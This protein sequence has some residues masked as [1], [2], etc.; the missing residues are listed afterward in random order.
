MNKNSL[1]TSPPEI[2]RAKEK[3][4]VFFSNLNAD[5]WGLTVL[6]LAVIALAFSPIFTKLGEIELSPTSTIF[7]RLW[8]ATMMLSCRQLVKNPSE[9]NS[10][11]EAEFRCDRHQQS[12][13]ILASF[14]ATVSAVLWAISLI[15][16]SVASSTVIRSLTPLFISTGAW[17][18]LKQRCDRQFAVGMMLA[19]VG[20]MA[21]GW[22]D[23][24][25]GA[26]RLVGDEIA[27]LSA[28][29]HGINLLII[30]YLRDRGCS[31]ER[32]LR[33][34]CGCGALLVFPVVYLT[35][36]Q[37]LPSSLQGWLAVIALAFICQTLGQGLLIHSLRQFSSS[38]VG[39]FTLLKPLITSVLAWAIFAE[40]I[41]LA[42]GVALILILTGIYLAKTSS[43]A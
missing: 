12:L 13:L 14:S 39:I 23:F 37:L 3:T 11:L 30:G 22:D 4:R 31:T 43:S 19:I 24:Q 5:I 21:I 8:I 16:T 32:V 27:L 38:F 15:H 34:R 20:G 10:I 7:N 25:L 33:W 42:G 40:N 36:T 26:D 29:L 35:D 2:D 1:L 18:I 9:L 6:T 17:L 41:S 28:A